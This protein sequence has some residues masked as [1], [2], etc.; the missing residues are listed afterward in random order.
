MKDI[1]LASSNTNC[2]F[3]VDED[4][5][6]FISQRETARLL[7]FHDN[8]IRHYIKKNVAQGNLNSKNQL[9]AKSFSLLCAH[10]AYKGNKQ[11]Q[12]LNSVMLEAGA[13]AF[14]YTSAGVSFNNPQKLLQDLTK[15][16]EE[17]ESTKSKLKL[18]V[19]NQVPEPEQTTELMINLTG[20]TKLAH[21][22]YVH[23]CDSEKDT[24]KVTTWK[25]KPKKKYAHW[26]VVVGGQ[27]R[28]K[29]K[30]YLEV[31]KFASGLG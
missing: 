14:I 31:K 1:R 29:E 13:T 15:T 24:K 4:G 17:L 25:H 9:D 21:E 6:A 19:D 2:N 26:F 23:T 8:T 18:V 10:Y 16:Q 20:N 7:G 30:Y 28:V 27:L 22:V 5:R 12:E 11:A 3:T